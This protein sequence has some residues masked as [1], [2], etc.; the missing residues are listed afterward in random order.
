MRQLLKPILAMSALAL[1]GLGLVTP[2][3]TA[4]AAM[5][6]PVPAY[7]HIQ[8]SG[9]QLPIELVKKKHHY[10]KH[11]H[12]HRYRDRRHG[13]GHYYRGYWYA[14][15]WWLGAAAVTAPYYAAPR[16]SY[17]GDAHV[18]WC[19]DRYRSYNPRTDTYRGYDGYD[20]RCISP[21]M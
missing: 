3:N 19:L 11:R 17:G 1:S 2:V 9:V 14:V 8:G 20:H 18:Q 15:P 7:S 21:Y 13:Y 6:S 4:S 5:V 10:N 12:G 16:P